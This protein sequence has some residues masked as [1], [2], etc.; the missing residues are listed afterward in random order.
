MAVQQAR[1]KAELMASAAG[2]R[3]KKISK[4]SDTDETEPSFGRYYVR[5]S[6][7]V[8]KSTAVPQLTAIPQTVSIDK[9]V[10]VVFDLAE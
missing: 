3:I 10:K 4:I 9:Q 7:V 8:D 1:A 6:R 5:S 2:R